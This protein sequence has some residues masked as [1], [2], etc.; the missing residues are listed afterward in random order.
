MASISSTNPQRF[1]EAT[2]RKHTDTND[3]APNVINDKAGPSH[4]LFFMQPILV[5]YFKTCL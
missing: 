5:H 4:W 3:L 1:L 2:E